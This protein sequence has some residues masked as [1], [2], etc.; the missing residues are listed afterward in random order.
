MIV[1]DLEDGVAPDRKQQARETVADVLETV[2]TA[3]EVCV[4]VNPVGAGA[5]TD[6]AF[7][8]EAARPDSLMLPKVSSPVDMKTAGQLC[9]EYGFDCPIV[10]IVETAAGVLSAGDI[11]AVD[12][13]DGLIFGAEDLAAD[14]G[15]T[16]TPDGSEV[17]YARQQ[18]VLAAR[19][20]AVDAIDTHHPAIEDETGLRAETERA[21]R[22]GYDGKMA[23]HPRQVEIINEA[24]RPDSEELAW[25][26]RI[27]D[28]VDTRG[29]GVTSID[30]EMI[31]APQIA[32]AKRI[33]DLADE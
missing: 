26:K 16:R 5:A 21:R 19:A 3:S 31:D 18:V 15:A 28:T 14:L 2:D 27:L 22:L 1:F 24:F 10:A 25:A 32:Q 17:A 8:A 33:V 7:L 13:T 6:F 29:Q 20:S 12:I 30:G 11:A 4:R 23:M 9:V